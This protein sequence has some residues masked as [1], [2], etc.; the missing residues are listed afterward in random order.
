MLPMKSIICMTVL[1]SAQYHIHTSCG[2]TSRL[3]DTAHTSFANFPS[4]KR[5]NKEK[6]K[7]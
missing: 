6:S 2:L 3:A 4:Y 1:R 7:S 5:A